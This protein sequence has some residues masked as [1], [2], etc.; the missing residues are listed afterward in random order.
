MILIM[1]LSKVECKIR[2][3]AIPEPIVI[4]G[5]DVTLKYLS[6]RLRK[7]MSNHITSSLF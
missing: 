2:G 5:D 6:L 3:G 4:R 7:L 1:V